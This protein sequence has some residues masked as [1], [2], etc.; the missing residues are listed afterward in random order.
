M[1]RT[2]G[3]GCGKSMMV[4]PPRARFYS[5]ACRVRA[6]RA[7]KTEPIPEVMR[8]TGRWMR[9]KLVT[10]GGKTTKRPLTV[11]GDPASST[12]PVTWSTYAK[13]EASTV[14]DGLGF[15]LGDGV[16]CYDLDDVLVAGEIAGWAREFIE[17]VPEPVLFMEVSQSGN[18]VHVFIEATEGPG[19]VIRDGRKIERYTAGRYI[20]VTGV[21]FKL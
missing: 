20:A 8:T 1:D 18:G 12:D 19:R 14:G 15:A 11:T 2:C 9:W 13:A 7:A 6:H 5:T 17:S 10:R 21:E 3:C 4:R 16:G